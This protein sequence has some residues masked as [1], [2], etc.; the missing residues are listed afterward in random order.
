MDIAGATLARFDDLTVFG[1]WA[2]G[3]TGTA[4]AIIV[5]VLLIYG[6]TRGVLVID[7]LLDGVIVTGQRILDNTLPLFDLEKTARLAEEIR[8]TV[9]AIEDDA[10]AVLSRAG[11]S[12][13]RG[14]VAR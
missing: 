4:I 7:A 5:V 9:A 12:Q 3:L 10:R 8:G 6:I 14:R 13:P 2:A 11:R 1:V